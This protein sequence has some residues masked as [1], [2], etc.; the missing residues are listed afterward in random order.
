[1]RARRLHVA[2]RAGS[3]P[4]DHARRKRPEQM[5]PSRVFLSGVCANRSQHVP[6]AAPALPCTPRARLRFEDN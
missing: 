5:R 1:M 6:Y 3:E 4:A 2:H